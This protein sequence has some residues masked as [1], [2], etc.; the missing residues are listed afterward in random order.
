M[1]DN[2]KEIISLKSFTDLYNGFIE[3][4]KDCDVSFNVFTMIS[5]KYHLENMHTDIIKCF[6]DPNEG[7]NEGNKFLFL[8]IDLINAIDKKSVNINKSLYANAKVKSQHQVDYKGKKGFIDILILGDKH[9]IIFENKIN[10]ASD[11]YNQ[12]PKYYG[13][14]SQKYTV[15]A[16]V[17]LPLSDYKTPDKETWDDDLA[18]LVKEKLIVLSAFKYNGI[19]FIDNWIIPCSNKTN[20][21]H[22]ISIL[23]Q[24]SNL[25]KSLKKETMSEGL[26]Y[27]L[28]ENNI[29]IYT[30]MDIANGIP[31][32]M[33]TFLLKQLNNDGDLKEFK[34]ASNDSIFCE[35]HVQPYNVHIDVL[36]QNYQYYLRVFEM[37]HNDFFNSDDFSKEINFGLDEEN[38]YYKKYRLETNTINNILNDIK[39][40]DKDIQTKF[41]SLDGQ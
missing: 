15:D 26:L 36:I 24:Y 18:K 4:Q 3:L 31:K 27:L 20:N 13:Y 21:I 16:I 10:N 32:A 9:C 2:I 37:N 12:L 5:D 35:Y 29:D 28:L 30:F 23:R 11:T 8:F 14:C 33:L 22:C 19:N 7:H 40:I 39:L 17:Y 6:L 41:R 25:V 34:P 1:E 38:K